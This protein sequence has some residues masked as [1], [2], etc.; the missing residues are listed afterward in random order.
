MDVITS[1]AFANIPEILIFRK[2]YN[3]NQELYL[4]AV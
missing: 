4:Q 1:Q 3:R 2:L